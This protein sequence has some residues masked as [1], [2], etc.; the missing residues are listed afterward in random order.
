MS[1]VTR[2]FNS[3]LNVV[4]PPR[5]VPDLPDAD[6]RDYALY[7][8][9]DFLSCLI[10]RRRMAEG[11]PPNPFRVPKK[12]I[13][14]HFP[15]DIK[16]ATL[17]GFGMIPGAG[18]HDSAPELGPPRI[19]EDSKDKF[20]PG[21]VLI[22]KSDYEETFT[23][24]AWGA[25]HAER[26]ALMAGVKCAL[27]SSDRSYAL[28]LTLPDY[29]NAVA[30]FELDDSQY[31]EDDNTVRNRRRGHLFIKLN[32]CEVGLVNVVDINPQFELEVLDGNVH[33]QLD[34]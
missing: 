20:G 34:C 24:E 28:Q 21:T 9:R 15:D 27:R 8:F 7:R 1:D 4:M 22:R 33:A 6:A 14:V 26:R 29:F 31:V 5:P 13:H 16:R 11:S 25:K 17:P 3:T 18:I 23:L 32:V 10:Y 19:L 12:S 30:S 2:P